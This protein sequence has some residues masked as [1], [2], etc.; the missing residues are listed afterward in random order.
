MKQIKRMLGVTLLEIMLVLAIAAM[1]ILMSVR[2]YQSATAATQTNALMGQ[3]QAITAAADGLTQA[4]G[5]YNNTTSPVSNTN[6]TPLLPTNTFISPWGLTITITNVT[7]NTYDVTITG[8]PAA[9]CPLLKT[10]LL[11]NNHF[12][13]TSACGATA[14]DFKYTYTANL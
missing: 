2:Y 8:T 7:A 1:I 10:R 6:L 11:A 3:V 5:A 9:V 12:T 14:A 4:Y 13:S